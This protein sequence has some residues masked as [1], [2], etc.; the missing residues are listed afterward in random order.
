[1]QR[2]IQDQCFTEVPDSLIRCINVEMTGLA[3]AG[4]KQVRKKNIWLQMIIFS[5]TGELNFCVVTSR[6][7]P[8]ATSFFS[9]SSNALL[10][11]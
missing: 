4:D 7:D 2:F 8:I 3:G 1:M 11:R 10:F 9:Y 6:Y 5:A